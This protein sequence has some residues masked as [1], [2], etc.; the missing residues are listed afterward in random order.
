M[1]F[2]STASAW[3]YVALCV[4]AG[5]LGFSLLLTFVEARMR[6]FANTVLPVPTT[7]RAQHIET[8][9]AAVLILSNPVL[10]WGGV[11]AIGLI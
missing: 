2:A 6:R 9:I 3:P 8:A 7:R 5:L 11:K 4:F 1:D 10:I